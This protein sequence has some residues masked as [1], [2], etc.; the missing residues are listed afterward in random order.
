MT[1]IRKKT[2]KGRTYY[3]EVENTRVGNKTTQK[4]LRYLGTADALA[5]AKKLTIPDEAIKNI[6]VHDIVSF[7]LPVA[8]LAVAEKLNLANII[9]EYI[10]KGGGINPG[11]STVL[12]AINR[13]DA[14]A[15]KSGVQHWYERTALKDIVPMSPD[16]LS[17]QNL[18][19][20]LDY[21]TPK[22]IM[23]IE[24]ALVEWYTKEFHGASVKP[25][26]CQINA[27]C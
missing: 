12:L 21:L 1:F 24:L 8:L 14:P 13:I 19:H 9:N 22:R 27:S 5:E 15:C 3:Y 25:P 7:G 17:C 26:A 16:K 20:L 10:P 6:D 2:I 11:L 18:C 4:V 23:D